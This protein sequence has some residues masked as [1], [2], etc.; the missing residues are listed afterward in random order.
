MSANNLFRLGSLLNDEG[1]EKMGRQTTAAFE[2]EMGQH[3]GL[4]SSMMPAVVASKLGGKK[5]LMVV[6]EGAFAEAALR[7]FNESITPNHTVLRVGGGV[8]SE[9][10]RSRN[11]LLKDV[12]GTKPMLQLCEGG[13]CK[14]LE[15]KDLER[16]FV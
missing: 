11:G 16:L 14:L 10:L 6:G 5:G 7:R 9:W 4:F 1:Y 3:P 8:K 15:E 12:D 13:V 2:V